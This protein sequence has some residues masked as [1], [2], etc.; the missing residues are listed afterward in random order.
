MRRSEEGSGGSLTRS[1]A[2][3]ALVP[4]NPVAGPRTPV[5]FIK[6][7]ASA[8][9]PAAATAVVSAVA[10]AAQ[11]TPAGQVQMPG[12]PDP[13]LYSSDSAQDSHA[14]LA[15]AVQYAYPRQPVPPRRA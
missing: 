4:Q 11:S 12:R 9:A 10:S 14:V 15:P 1:S 3:A 7:A 2:S 6:A 5:T 13:L 8:V